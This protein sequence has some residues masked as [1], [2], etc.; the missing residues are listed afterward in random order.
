[1]AGGGACGRCV[2]ETCRD[3]L[4]EC[5]TTRG[6][7]TKRARS[8][9]ALHETTLGTVFGRTLSGTWRRSTGRVG[10]GPNSGARVVLEFAPTCA[11]KSDLC[12][13][14]W[15]RPSHTGRRTS[16][17]ARRATPRARA[18]VPVG[19]GDATSRLAGR[20]W[21]RPAGRRGAGSR[22]GA[23]RRRGCARFSANESLGCIP[24]RIRLDPAWPI[25]PCRENGQAGQ[26]TPDPCDGPNQTWPRHVRCEASAAEAALRVA[27]ALPCC[28]AL[29]LHA[30]EVLL[31]ERNRGPS[32][33]S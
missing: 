16:L 14:G 31:E 21:R 22:R 32:R 15:T 28:R 12:K 8:P 6:K 27:S 20:L 13:P 10:G 26:A 2:R 17:A 5:Q 18:A 33:R 4:S 1:M 7:L 19:F 3:F 25:W 11:P 29:E 24:G 30:E 9:A 23:P